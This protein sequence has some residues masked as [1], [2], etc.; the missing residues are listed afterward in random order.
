MVDEP[1][2]DGRGDRL[3][4]GNPPPFVKD[5]VARKDSG[6]PLV[7]YG[8]KLEEKVRLFPGNRHIAKFV[9]DKEVEP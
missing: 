3:I 6:A 8:D 7:P 9:D 4:I 2:N 5:V 1:V